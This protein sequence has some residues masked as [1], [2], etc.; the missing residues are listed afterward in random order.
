MH[1]L[2]AI[3]KRLLDIQIIM[4][5]TCLHLHMK[6]N[7]KLTKVSDQKTCSLLVK[8]ANGSRMEILEIPKYSNPLIL[9]C[10]KSRYQKL[11]K[12]CT[13]FITCNLV[14]IHYIPF[15]SMLILSSIFILYFGICQL[16]VLV[17]QYS[18][19]N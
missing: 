19:Q 15:S 8:I 14:K 18:N 16:I 4:D 13:K 2:T 5:L 11:S 3:K 7:F 9:W 12:T 17:E 1:C 10:I 6:K